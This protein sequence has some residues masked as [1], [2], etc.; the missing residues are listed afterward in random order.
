M[1]RLHWPGNKFPRKNPINRAMPMLRWPGSWNGGILQ[2]F[3]S[4]AGH[5]PCPHAHARLA[6][7]RVPTG[8]QHIQGRRMQCVVSFP[9]GAWA[10]YRTMGISFFLGLHGSPHGY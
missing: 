5:P 3:P 10:Q 2:R 8:S 6:L 9:S 7:E 4:R 1:V